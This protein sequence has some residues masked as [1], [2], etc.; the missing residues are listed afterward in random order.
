MKWF[1]TSWCLSR[2]RDRR[3]E[4]VKTKIAVF[5]VQM[6]AAEHSSRT[7]KLRGVAVTMVKREPFPRD[8]NQQSLSKLGT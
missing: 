7:V 4:I 1:L 5:T 6:N 8:L 3:V 2:Y